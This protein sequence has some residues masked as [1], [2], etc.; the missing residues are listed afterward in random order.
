VS[1]YGLR[2]DVRVHHGDDDDG[3]DAL[4]LALPLLQLVPPLVMLFAPQQLQHYL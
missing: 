2:L 1:L 3:D 4:K